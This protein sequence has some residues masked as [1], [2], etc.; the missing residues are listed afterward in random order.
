LEPVNTQYLMNNMKITSLILGCL[1]WMV[2]FNPTYGQRPEV[3]L[4]EEFK[5]GNNQS[6]AG[7][8]DSDGEGHYL[9]YNDK[10]KQM[11]YQSTV[12][13]AKYDYDFNEIWSY[14]YVP[15]D[16]ETNSYGLLSLNDRFLWL[17]SER[18]EK[19]ERDYFLVSI[20]KQGEI[21]KKVKVN[22]LKFR[23]KYDEPYVN[24]MACEDSTMVAVMQTFDRDK[25]DLDYEYDV[26]VLNAELNVMWKKSIW[27]RKKSQEQIDMI[28]SALGNDGSFYMLVKEYD[29]RNAKETKKKKSRKGKKKVPAYD[30]KIYKLSEGM[31]KPEVIKLNL[32]DKFAKGASLRI[33]ES[34]TL[35][36]VG[37]YSD[38]RNGNIHGV[39]YQ[40]M[41]PSGKV[42]ST[43]VK[44]F[45][46]KDLDLLG[47]RNSDEDKDGSS[48]IEGDFV[49]N[50]QLTLDDGTTVI[51]AEH[52][53]SSSYMDFNGFWQT[54]FHSND[55]I[56]IHFESDGNIK[57]VN[58]IPKRQ[59]AGNNS[60]LSHKAIALEGH[61]VYY[62]YNDHKDNVD[63]GLNRRPKPMTGTRNGSTTLAHIDA[64]GGLQ[65]EEL[66]D[67]RR[68]RSLFLPYTCKR[69]DENS[70]F[71]VAMRPKTMKRASFLMGVVEF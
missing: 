69:I 43:Q 26:A 62:L 37:M 65:R 44:E 17:F 1:V 11:R 66:F 41:D 20:D 38:K 5:M 67:N 55:I 14:D 18:P 57:G 31:D 13:L 25:D 70:I 54:S 49:F 10:P 71:F 35:T 3:Y 63:R 56:I 33:D 60:F 32:K 47:K 45:S 28:N 46:R 21:G 8:L 53:Y 39:F 6:F 2:L 19:T 23:K 4:S 61:P 9:Y 7:H 42:I 68:M 30:L 29:D 27:L 51:T 12:V 64:S 24:W 15:D 40:R 16:D 58:L 48:S 59:S 52:S 36:A 34:G 22:S 50:D